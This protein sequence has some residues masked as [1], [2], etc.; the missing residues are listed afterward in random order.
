MNSL[1]IFSAQLV[2]SD[3][4]GYSLAIEERMHSLTSHWT[5]K[6][7]HQLNHTTNGHKSKFYWEK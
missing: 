1:F 3:G 2:L 7:Y 6:H 5:E 4:L